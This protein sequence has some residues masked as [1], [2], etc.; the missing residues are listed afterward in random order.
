MTMKYRPMSLM[1][2]N[3]QMIYGHRAWLSSVGLHNLLIRRMAELEE[4]LFLLEEALLDVLPAMAHKYIISQG[5]AQPNQMPYAT[6]WS[7]GT[8][9]S[10]DL[11]SVLQ[12]FSR[13]CS[14][15]H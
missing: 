1:S 13:G 7:G 10:Q 14:G 11:E 15:P 6:L 3:A 5:N 2:F 9:S 4:R 12:M 8:L